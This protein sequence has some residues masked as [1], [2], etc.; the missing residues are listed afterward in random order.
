[1]VYLPMTVGDEDGIHR[2]HCCDV[3]A[4]CTAS[5]ISN[6][7]IETVSG[8]CNTCFWYARDVFLTAGTQAYQKHV[9][10]GPETVSIFITNLHAIF[11]D[12]LRKILTIFYAKT[13]D[14]LY[15]G[16]S[17]D[18]VRHWQSS[19]V[20]AFLNLVRSM[21]ST[22]F[23]N[24]CHMTFNAFTF[25]VIFCHITLELSWFICFCYLAI[26]RSVWRDIKFA[27]CVFCFFCTVED[28]STQDGAIGVKFWLRVEQTSWTG[29]R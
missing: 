5:Q 1:M 2:M 4:L 14:S 21:R 13:W 26:Q 23:K 19:H 16:R 15:C 27:F 22:T 17:P 10:H 9:L 8:P 25:W 28:I 29:T 11:N 3:I 6:K 18:V 12:I 7:N 20:R 24:A